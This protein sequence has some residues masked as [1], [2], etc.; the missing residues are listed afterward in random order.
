MIGL[1]WSKL[2][3]LNY[4]RAHANIHIVVIRCIFNSSV[5]TAVSFCCVYFVFERKASSIYLHIHPNTAQQLQVRSSGSA[6]ALS[7][8]KLR[9]GELNYSLALQRHAGQTAVLQALTFFLLLMLSTIVA[10]LYKCYLLLTS[11]LFTD[12]ES[13]GIQRE[14]K[15]ARLQE[16][17]TLN[18]TYNCSS[19]FTRGYWTWENTP[20][21][22]KCQWKHER[23]NLR[24]MCTVSLYTSYLV[25][26]QTHY[27]YSCH[28]EESDRP[29]LP[30]KTELL[31]TLQV[32]GKR[33]LSL[34]LTMNNLYC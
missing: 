24:D 32:H 25:M 22:S 8:L 31:V 9:P 23:S 5:H 2:T 7:S 14:I 3:L 18:C 6:E 16:P 12:A 30:R 29:G 17:F 34:L 11:W 27:N 10:A 21:C 20:P 15:N 28:V 19:G 1:Y 26:E 13:A 4:C 33:C